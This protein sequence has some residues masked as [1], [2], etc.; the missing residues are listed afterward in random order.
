M[1]VLFLPEVREYL[2]E[3]SHICMRTVTSAFWNHRKN[4]WRSLLMTL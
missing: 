2:N 4:T 1:K 3:V